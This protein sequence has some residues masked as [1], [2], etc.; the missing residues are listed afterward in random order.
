MRMHTCLLILRFPAIGQDL[1][2]RQAPDSNEIHIGQCGHDTTFRVAL[3]A[4]I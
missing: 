2:Q 1:K 3:M 4:A